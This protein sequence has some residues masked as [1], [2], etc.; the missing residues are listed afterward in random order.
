MDWDAEGL[1]DGL[2]DGAR[3]ERVELLDWLD[4]RG[5]TLDQIRLASDDGLLLMLPADRVVS[6][7]ERFTLG[8]AAE[9]AGVHPEF[10]GLL[11]RVNG[12]PSPDPRA[13]DL[14]E[15]D[16]QLAEVARQYAEL[17]VDAEQLQGA[18]RA[19]GRALSGLAGSLRALVFELV[20]Q[21]GMSERE[22]AAAYADR[23]EALMPL[24]SPM[25]DAALRTQ[26]RQAVRTELIDAAERAA[27]SL[28]G[29]REV[30]VA[31]ADIVGFTK[32]GEEVD[33]AQL[34]RVAA[35]L[36]SR[37]RELLRP[38]VTL[39]KSIGD[40]VLLVS[41]D[42]GPLLD[43]CLELSATAEDRA[44][45]AAEGD[46]DDL[47]QLRIGLSFGP[48]LARGGD[49][50]GRAVNLASRVAAAAR[51]GSVLVTKEVRDHAA[52]EAA[53]WSAAG[54]KHFKGVSGAVRLYRARP[55][56]HDAE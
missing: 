55:P 26:L 20:V 28:P 45:E 43:L 56:A 42:V 38:P 41:P 24:M 13:A 15:A 9:Q 2:E 1:L 12:L 49:W 16:V 39:V 47:P 19:V 48:A 32:L 52:D 21:P 40:A 30:A 18:A 10:L 4:D 22:L 46:G 35:R 44:R 31:F 50:F 37:T 14:S 27:G 54:S 25:L 36:E 23:V 51:P 6:G 33:T 5:F 17:G 11:R 8:E 29:E 53:R 7:D 34:E 3:A